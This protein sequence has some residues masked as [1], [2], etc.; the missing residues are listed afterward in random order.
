MKMLIQARFS[1]EEQG[2]SV[3]RRPSCR[4][5]RSPPCHPF[6]QRI[7]SLWVTLRSGSQFAKE[8]AVGPGEYRRRLPVLSGAPTRNVWFGRL[9]RRMRLSGQQRPIFAAAGTIAG[10]GKAIDDQVRSFCG[11]M[12]LFELGYDAGSPVTPSARPSGTLRLYQATSRSGAGGSVAVM[13]ARAFMR[14]SHAS[15]TVSSRMTLPSGVAA[16]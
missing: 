10:T 2:S 9:S 4:V 3:F 6:N 12:E 14:S 13:L 1:P 15:K 16:R 5:C 11:C 8:S 7:G